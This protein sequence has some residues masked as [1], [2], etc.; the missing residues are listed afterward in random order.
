MRNTAN[1][2]FIRDYT[3]NN[4]AKAEEILDYVLAWTNARPQCRRGSRKYKEMSI[5]IDIMMVTS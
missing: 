3:W 2:M 4:K 5:E 1:D